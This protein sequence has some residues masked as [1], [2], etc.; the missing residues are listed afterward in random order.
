[1]CVYF[2]QCRASHSESLSAPGG[3]GG[4]AALLLSYYLMCD[5]VN[6]CCSRL[7][8]VAGARSLARP[9]PCRLR[10]R[11]LFLEFSICCCL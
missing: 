3:G 11:S 1:M 5:P 6:K 2:C 4:L 10:G 7:F 8:C 9:Q